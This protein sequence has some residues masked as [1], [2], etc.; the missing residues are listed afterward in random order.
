M[1]MMIVIIVIIV[2]VQIQGKEDAFEI[3]LGRSGFGPA[4]GCE[5]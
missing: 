3:R 2:A 4:V 1:I 5:A